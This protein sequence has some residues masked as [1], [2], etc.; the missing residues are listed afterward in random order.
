MC[1]SE[2]DVVSISCKF[3][4]PTASYDLQEHSEEVSFP[5]F[6]FFLSILSTNPFIILQPGRQVSHMEQK[7]VQNKSKDEIK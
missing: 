7:R 4:T 6:Q 2:G 3:L 1:F 5:F